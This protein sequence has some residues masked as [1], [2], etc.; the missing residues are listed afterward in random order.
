MDR[1]MARRNI[2]MGVALFALL[3]LM[4]GLAFAWAFLYLKYV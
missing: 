3:L 1:E 4:V 2:T